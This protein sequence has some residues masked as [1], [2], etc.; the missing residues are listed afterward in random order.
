MKDGTVLDRSGRRYRPSTIRGYESA[1]NR[2]VIPAL[3][4]LRGTEV[5]RGDVQRLVDKL[6]PKMTG[7]TSRGASRIPLASRSCSTRCR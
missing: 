3:G 6:G 5:R 4:H 7:T 1:A 2:Y